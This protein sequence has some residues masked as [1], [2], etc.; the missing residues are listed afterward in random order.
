MISVSKLNKF[1]GSH[2]VLRDVSFEVKK[3]EIVGF[4]GQNAAGKTTLMRILT[5]YIKPTSGYVQIG[6]HRLGRDDLKIRRKIGY[7][8]E[9]PPLYPSLYVEEYLRFAAQLKDVPAKHQSKCVEDVLNECHL[10][11]VR[12]KEIAYLSKG[13][14]QRV[15]IAQAL[16]NDPEILILDE[17]TNGLDPVQIIQVRDLIRKLGSNRII[18]VSTHILPEIEQ[19]AQRLLLIKDGQVILDGDL[20]DILH[21]RHQS[22]EE[23]FLK[24]H[25]SQEKIIS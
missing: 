11:E 2:H 8:P 13:Y 3:G 10:K 12:H 23:I 18:I 20:K 24:L 17:P 14:K 22:L 7:L 5:T 21:M 19:L 1:Y 9:N 16:I 15:G 6:G 4:L 25:G